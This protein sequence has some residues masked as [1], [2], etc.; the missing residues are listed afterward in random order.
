[1]QVPWLERRNF[2]IRYVEYVPSSFMV[3]TASAETSW[4]TPAFS[5]TTT[6]PASTAARYSMPV[7]T[8]GLSLRISGTA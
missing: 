1:M 8:S 5:A 4:T 6:S 2:A 7:P 3:S